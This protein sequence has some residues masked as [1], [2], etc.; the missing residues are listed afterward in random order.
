MKSEIL[1][2]AQIS[3]DQSVIC[4]LGSDHIPEKLKLGK[5]ENDFAHAQIQVKKEYIIINS[6]NKY[7]YLIRLK[8]G[9]S[10]YKVREAL[11]KTAYNLRKLIKGNNHSELVITS[12]KAYKGAIEDF[13]EGLI[14]SFYSFE[15]Y[16][17]IEEEGEKNNY[18]AR[19]LLHGKIADSEIKWLVDL[20]DAVYFTRDLIKEPV[21]QLNATSLAEE[22]KKLGDAAGFKVEILAKGKIEALKMGGL[23]AVNKGSVDPPV[24]CILDWHPANCLNKKP[25]VLVGKGIVY[26]TGGLNIK[27]GEFMAGMNGDMAGAAIVT[28]VIHTAAKTGIPLHIIGLIPSTDNRPGG[29]AYTQGDI[30]TMYNKMTV[31]IGN[32]DAE[33]RLILADAISYASKYSPELIIDIATLT[34]SAAMTFGN[35]AIAVMTNADRKYID[36]LEQCGNE[37]YER[38]AELPLWEEYG[39][40]LKSDI[41]DLKSIGGR[42]AGAIIAGKFIERFA[43]YPL[44]HMDIAG[45]EILKKDDF[46]RIKNGPAS[47]LRLL[48]TFLRRIAASYSEKK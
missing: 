21:N 10:H 19:L 9:I 32:T 7:I 11:R 4:I 48:S 42:E 12:D 2:I 39:E 34:G 20:T 8:E 28:G 14:L 41:A 40:L 35:Q 5:S 44:M 31:E 6:Y 30:I 18:P 47:G 25:F 36:L 22:I 24:F 38:I 27:T 46:Y 33:G 13:A 15:K 29:N 1:R 45:T 3:P 23:L 16:K 26:D 43:E 37:V 17:T